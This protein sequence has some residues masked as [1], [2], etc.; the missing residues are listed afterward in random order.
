M[1]F[2]VNRFNVN[3]S[4]VLGLGLVAGCH[5]SEAKKEKESLSTFQVYLETRHD[6]T[7]RSKIVKVGRDH[8]VNFSVEKE[9]FASEKFVKAAKVVSEVGGFA[10]QV[11]LDRQGSWLLEQYTTANHG[12][13]LV[14]FS[15]FAIP[16]DEKLNEGRWL[17]APRI[18]NN[19]TNGLLSF[20]ADVTRA[21]ADQIA[22]GLNHVAKHIQD[23]SIIQ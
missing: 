17:A 10:L 11:Q 21:E 9:P 1:K 3:L 16:P 22:L 19:I 13:H 4:L 20:T 5:T 8:P 15:Q 7:D 12:K 6:N 14:I 18:T 2:C 23:D